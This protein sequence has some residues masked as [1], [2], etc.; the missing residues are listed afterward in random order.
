[1]TSKA[2]QGRTDTK[3][4]EQEICVFVTPNSPT[5]FGTVKGERCPFR[6]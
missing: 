2:N 5:C 6:K 1:M 3:E 4:E